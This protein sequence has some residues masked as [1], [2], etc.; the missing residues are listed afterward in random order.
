MTGI[1]V[2]RLLTVSG[3]QCERFGGRLVYYPIQP[4]AFNGWLTPS[5]DGDHIH[6]LSP[7]NRNRCKWLCQRILSALQKV[8][9]ANNYPYGHYHW[10]IQGDFYG[11]M[12]DGYL[13]ETLFTALLSQT[14]NWPLDIYGR[15]MV[16]SKAANTID[17]RYYGFADIY[18]TLLSMDHP[19][20]LI[21]LDTL[22]C[23]HQYIHIVDGLTIQILPFA[24]LL[25]DRIQRLS[26]FTQ[27][28]KAAFETL[29][30]FY[31]IH[32]L[33]SVSGSELNET[34]SQL[35]PKEYQAAH[36]VIS[37]SEA[38]DAIASYTKI[39]AWDL[40][41]MVADLSFTSVVTTRKGRLAYGHLLA[42]HPFCN[43]IRKIYP[44]GH[45]GVLLNWI[46]I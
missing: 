26:A 34:K 41:R 16:A 37:Q 25:K 24:R 1:S 30:I 33:A 19:Q 29:G 21:Y 11:V 42:D 39:K 23:Q 7:V 45:F 15:A 2:N 27:A 38:S 35:S 3:V 10:Y 43:K 31:P 28:G 4:H 12:D 14:E 22:M 13:L 5:L 9:S 40:Y 32:S 6:I 46:K 17:P 18:A 20:D 44:C 8:A 36:Y